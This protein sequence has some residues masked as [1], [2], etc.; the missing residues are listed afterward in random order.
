MAEN[1]AYVRQ[2]QEMIDHWFKERQNNKEADFRR[3][4]DAKIRELQR[5]LDDYRRNH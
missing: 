4:A 3:M 2:I 5:E 1:D